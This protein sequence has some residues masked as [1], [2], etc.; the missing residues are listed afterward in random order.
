[1]ND[2]LDRVEQQLTA[3]TD[4]GA[5]QRL[6]ARRPGLDGAGAGGPTGPK[7]PRRLTEGLTVLAAAAVVAAVVAI[8]L[9]NSHHSTSS[10][11][12][13]AAA[14]SLTHSATTH[15]K[16]T[17]PAASTPTKSTPGP[18]STPIPAHFATQ[19]F[20]AISELEWWVLSA[21]PC[22]FPGGHPPCGS[23]LRTTDGGQH[24]TG[25]GE[26]HASLSSD[27]N[28]SGYSQI[29]FADS[30][31]GYAFGPNLYVTHDG[32]QTWHP[33]NVGGAVSD[34]AIAD[35]EAYA[36][37]DVSGS[38]AAGARLMHSA[39]SADGWTVVPAAGDVSTGLWV[40]GSDVFVQSGVA[41]GIGSD[42]LVSHD[43]GASFA[44]YPSPSPGLGCQYQEMEPPVVWAHCATG[45]ESGIWRST[46]AAATFDT[47]EPSGRL[48]LP[49]S[50]PFAAASAST[51]VVGYQQLYQTSD[52][53]GTYTPVKITQ[54]P[55]ADSRVAAWAWLGF[56]DQ[57]HGVALGY[58]GSVA[59]ANE[60]L[61]YSVDGGQTYH[62]VPV[63]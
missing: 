13:A 37:V 18:I 33:L 6:R 36:I 55:A 31:N 22:Q 56:T 15:P 30:D 59:P 3:L 14:A 61:F 16:T 2:Y 26:P 5:H 62:Y 53:G 20:T 45:T 63:P 35:G 29:R 39:V 46:D 43:G 9:I 34:L 38:G 19:S 47:A 50:A 49:N 58:V 28:Q 51:A 7:G 27:P 24:F 32:G 10:H 8:V 42:V 12:N 60:R 25:I 52:D 23:I 1:M 21:A 54:S 17:T 11:S 4:G 57:T 41:N 44:G 48:S 40:F